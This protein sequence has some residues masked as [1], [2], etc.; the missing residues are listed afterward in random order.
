MKRIVLTS[1]LASAAA[2]ALMADDPSLT[3][4]WQ[5]HTSIA[6]TEH[7]QSCSFTQ[8]GEDLT[9]TCVSETGTVNITGKVNGTKVS[10][11][12]KSE[13]NGSPLTVAHDGVVSS[14][15][16]ITGSVSVPEFSV[17]GDFT[18]TQSK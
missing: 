5:V 10:W 12:Y 14:G 2:L 17:E 4:K 1:L 13:Y 6:G 18:A 15:T 16:K 8:K 3:G 9:G 11:S 7:D